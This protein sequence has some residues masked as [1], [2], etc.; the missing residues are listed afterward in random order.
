VARRSRSTTPHA[1]AGRVAVDGGAIADGDTVH[2]DT[3][4]V[5]ATKIFKLNGVALIGG[6]VANAGAIEIISSFSI[7]NAMLGNRVSWF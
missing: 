2:I 1:D 3:V 6:S 7:E 5:D 4:H